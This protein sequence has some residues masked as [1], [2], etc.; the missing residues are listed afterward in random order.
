MNI[1][2]IENGGENK[3][4]LQCIN[5]CF[6]SIIYSGINPCDGANCSEVQ[7][8][9]ID[10]YG[11]TKCECGPECEP[12]MKPVCARGGTTYKS[13]CELKRQACITKSNIEVAYTGTCGSRGPC[14]EKV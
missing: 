1:Q 9:E 12:V 2:V 4:L 5:S 14:S 3:L 7:Q 6:I 8:C 11:I 10:R 13:L